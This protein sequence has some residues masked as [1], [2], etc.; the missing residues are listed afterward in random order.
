[1]SDNIRLTD[2]E[3]GDLAKQAKGFKNCKKCLEATSDAQLRKVVEFIEKN[4]VSCKSVEVKCNPIKSAL[5]NGPYSANI[6]GEWFAISAEAWAALKAPLP[7]RQKQ[8]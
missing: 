8:P 1:M 7:E 6:Y 3:H 2:K 5:Q 4:G